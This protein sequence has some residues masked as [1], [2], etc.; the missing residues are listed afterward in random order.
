MKGFVA[1]G[2]Q[3]KVQKKVSLDILRRLG[4][5][6][7]GLEE[8][9]QGE[10]SHFIDEVTQMKGQAFNPRPLLMTSVSNVVTALAFGREFR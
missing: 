7:G 8:I 3:W 2:H 9:V 1:S 4:A 6:S 10:I 5:Q